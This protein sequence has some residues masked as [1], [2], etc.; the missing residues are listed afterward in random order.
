[1]GLL[2]LGRFIGV[3]VWLSVRQARLNQA[4]RQMGEG[5]RG[6]GPYVGPKYAGPP[7]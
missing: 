7:E 5:L 2:L 3:G 4:M 6:S 1:M